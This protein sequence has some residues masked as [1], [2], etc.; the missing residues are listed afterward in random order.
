MYYLYINDYSLLMRYVKKCGKISTGLFRT[1]ILKGYLENVEDDD[2]NQE[3][4]KLTNKFEITFIKSVNKVDFDT[5]FIEFWS[6]YP[7]KV[8][9][10]LSERYL[11]I[12][13]EVCKNLYKKIIID[14]N[15][16]DLEKHNLV[17]QCLKYE[18]NKKKKSGDMLYMRNSATWLRNKSWE[19]YKDEV[20]K[21][22]LNKDNLQ[23][24]EEGD[25]II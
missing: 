18:V 17:I 5:C 11:R 21:L 13:K 24:E 2:F 14:K 16:V 10:G 7:A 6:M 23:E 19:P 15:S 12:D 22:I 3:S 9:E 1:L 25:E 4:L 20:E 8:K